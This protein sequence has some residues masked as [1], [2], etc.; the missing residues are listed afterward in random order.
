MSF[1]DFST[2]GLETILIGR[3][4]TLSQVWRRGD[5]EDHFYEIDLNLDQWFKRESLLK[6]FLCC[7]FFGFGLVAQS[8]CGKE[9]VSSASP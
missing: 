7:F 5:Y 2:L 4:A 9:F 3:A 8:V 1:K 6:I